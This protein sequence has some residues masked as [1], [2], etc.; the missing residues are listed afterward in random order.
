MVRGFCDWLSHHRGSSEITLSRYGAAVS[1][2]LTEL[3]DDPSQYDAECLRSFLLHRAQRRGVG[4]TKAILSPVRM[5]LRYLAIEG[6][7][8]PGLDAAIPA[9][10]GW[11][12]ASLPRC[13]SA[14]EVEQLLAACDL[15]LPIGLR[16]HA[17]ILLLA[18]LG[19]RA[20]DVAEL[21]FADINWN[22]GSILL[23]GKSRRE[24]RLPLPQEVG[25]A[26]LAY[27]EHRPSVHDDHVFL[28]DIAPFIALPGS[29]VSQIVR[30][31][32]RR[33]GIVAPSHGSHIL[34]HTAATEMLRRGVS[35]YDIGSVL[36]HRSADRSAYYAKVDMEFLKQIVQPWPEVA[37]C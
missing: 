19:L 31:N 23:K 27:L 2:L 3:G 8:K 20:G 22:D 21:R 4:G 9:I 13:L 10:A 15:A 32:M 33:A 35:L 18:R 14:D 17:V 28:R 6:K 5:F 36:R 7:C 1:A 25:D 29:S 37:P 30:R 26:I 24:A 11:R 16:D 34:R 12:L